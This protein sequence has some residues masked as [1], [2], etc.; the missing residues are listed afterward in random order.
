MFGWKVNGFF[1]S[2]W[3]D[4]GGELWKF[5][6]VCVVR[7]LNILGLVCGGGWDENFIVFVVKGFFVLEVLVEV[8]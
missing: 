1:V 3:V 2:D 7:I 4:V 5:F 8:F 6:I